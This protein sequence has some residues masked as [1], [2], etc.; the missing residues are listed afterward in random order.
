MKQIVFLIIIILW[1]VLRARR[2]AIREQQKRQLANLPIPGSNNVYRRTP[3]VSEAADED[4]G[5]PELPPE[6]QRLLQYSRQRMPEPVE[7][8]V[9]DE[10]PEVV[11]QIVPQRTV[12]SPV[13]GQD[14][15]TTPAATRPRFAFN[16]DALRTFVVT[17]EVLGPARSR[18]PF[19]IRPKAQE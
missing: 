9:E 17:R 15:Y 1:S 6:V 4:S 19:R 8:Q 2:K 7:R 14:A 18:K 13:Q 11:E 16:R 12:E 10:Q 3:P 5:E